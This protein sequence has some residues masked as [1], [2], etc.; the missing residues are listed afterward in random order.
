MEEEVKRLCKLYS[1]TYRVSGQYLRIVS[2]RDA[3]YI[4]NRDHEGRAI[5]LEHENA[6][7]HIGM[8]LHGKHKNIIDTFKAIYSHD[9]LDKHYVHNKPSRIT[10]LLNQI[11]NVYA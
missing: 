11:H 8:H 3:W 2:S 5:K 9:N 10:G 1:Y 4:L 7:G 6:H